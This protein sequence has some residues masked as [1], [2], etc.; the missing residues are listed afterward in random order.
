MELFP[1]NGYGSYLALAPTIIGAITLG[2]VQQITKA[3][4][5][6]RVHYNIWLK[7]VYNC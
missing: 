7:L 6:L 4:E 2:F 3:L 1:E 5:E